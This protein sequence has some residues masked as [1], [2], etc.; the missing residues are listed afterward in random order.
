M[1]TEYLYV[2]RILWCGK[3]KHTRCHCTEE[4]ILFE[5]PEAIRLESTL[6]IRDVPETDEEMQAMGRVGTSQ[7]GG[8]VPR[9]PDGTIKKMWER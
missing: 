4:H 9:H 8:V 2:W 1:R 5:H 7:W 6:I 3:W